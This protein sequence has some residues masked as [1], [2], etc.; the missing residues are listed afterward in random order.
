M[1]FK[2]SYQELKEL[3]QNQSHFGGNANLV[4]KLRT[5]LAWM[6]T[7]PEDERYVYLM[8]RKLD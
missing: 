1:T 8:G 3:Q 2:I 7:M 4:S 5:I 6:E